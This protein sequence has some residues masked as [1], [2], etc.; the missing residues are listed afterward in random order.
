MRLYCLY[1]P[2]HTRCQRTVYA[3]LTSCPDILPCRRYVHGADIV[4]RVPAGLNYLHHGEERFIPSFD[5]S[6]NVSWHNCKFGMA[7]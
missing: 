6:D 5:V 4:P 2:E 7:V 3:Q 1:S